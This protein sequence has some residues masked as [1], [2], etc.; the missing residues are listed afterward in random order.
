MTSPST[1]I[2]VIEDE[3]AHAEAICRSLEAMDG[4]ELRVMTTLQEFQ[5]E[6]A[7]WNP[8][9][10]LMDLHLP[11]GRALEVL[12][13]PSNSRPFAIIVM[14][15][16]GSE[17]VAVEALKSGAFD[18]LV[19]S[20]ETFMGLPRTLERL[21]REW[22]LRKESRRM[23]RELKASEEK[24]RTL[25]DHAG[26]AILIHDLQLRILAANP[27]ACERMGYTASEL[28][29]MT[30]SQVEIPAMAP[31]VPERIALLLEQ[32]HVSFE[33]VQRGKD[34]S[35]RPM[36]VNAR[37][38][39]WDG[40]VV[41]LSICRDTT[42]RKQAE[43]ERRMLDE[44]MS[45][46]Q[47]LEALGVLVAGVAHNINNVLAAIMGTASLRERL[48][49]DPLELEACGIIGTACKRGRDVVKSLLQFAQPSLS[50]QAPLELHALITELRVLLENTTRNRI[51]ILESFYPEPLWVLGDA[52]GLS[53]ALM[54][55]C[56][57]ALDAMPG[58][59][60]L[61]LSTSAP[62]TGW[63]E[64]CVEDSGEGMSPEVLARVLEP[65]FTTKPVGKGTGLGLS[66]TRGVIK[67]HGG[68]LEISSRLGQGTLV[69][70]RIPRISV[71]TLEA[72]PLT[73]VQSLG[74]M[75][76]LLVDDDVDVRF[77]VTRMLKAVGLRVQA[78]S[79]GEE[80]LKMLGDGAKPDLIILDQN[81]P[82]MNG[83]QTME[84]IRVMNQEVP[85]LISSGQPDIEQWPCFQQPRVAVIAKP[86]DMPE[87][88]AKL[89]GFALESKPGREGNPT[90]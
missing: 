1:R 69:R 39:L 74:L 90:D 37:K 17:Q 10:V 48:A 21:L 26:D 78:A 65:F 23:D 5:A 32:G 63:I 44:R 16:F 70:L 34:G 62:E 18:Y 82:G 41:V 20:P 28:T 71:P 51:Q 79:G 43:E 58:G 22:Q 30:V 6:G 36:E 47:K 60:T 64:V 7:S 53:N 88:L 25:F 66:M 57:N 19:K 29:S 59:G 89:E 31:R 40:E 8:D 2:L 33:T 83:T 86:F 54:N 27:R 87:I 13:D 56:L 49:T 55:L 67:A 81:M 52:G 80:A 14:T 72:A 38:I 24:Y 76:V 3:S 42:E 9:L 84:R 77:L 73:P 12:P 15:S 46:V 68:T 85:I 45:Q 50:N 61:T 4:V 75:N 11:D 35:L